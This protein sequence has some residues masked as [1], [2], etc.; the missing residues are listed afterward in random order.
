MLIYSG[1]LRM[2]EVVRLKPTDIDSKKMLIFIKAGKGRKVRYTLLSP[3]VLGYLRDYWK[4]YKPTKWLFE[5]QPDGRS[6]SIRSVENI[7]IDARDRAGIL[8]QVSVHSLR[9]SFATHLLEQ[10]VD[11]RIIQELLGHMDP[12]TTEIYT[13]VSERI[14]RNI[15]CPIK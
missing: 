11:V 4:V 7:F 13:H 14:L 10:G 8:K 12:R 6:N 1:G 3:T 15:E 2:G 9:H 5:G